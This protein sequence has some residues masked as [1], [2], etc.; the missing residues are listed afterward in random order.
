M[1]SRVHRY[2]FSLFRI[3]YVTVIMRS[4]RCWISHDDLIFRELSCTKTFTY[5]TTKKYY[6]LH[7]VH[8]IW[9]SML[10]IIALVHNIWKNMLLIIA[11]E[12]DTSR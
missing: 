12:Q 11:Y 1:Q 3:K 6:V 4:I 5:T 9:K 8:N 7:L 10:L 2:H